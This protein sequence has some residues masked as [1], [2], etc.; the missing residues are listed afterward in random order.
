MPFV[1]WKFPFRCLVPTGYWFKTP[2]E[3]KSVLNTTIAADHADAVTVLRLTLEAPG[4]VAESEPQCKIQ[5]LEIFGLTAQAPSTAV[6]SLQ[7]STSAQFSLVLGLLWKLYRQH[8]EVEE[9]LAK[10]KH[11]ERLVEVLLSQL[12]SSSG[13]AEAQ[14]LVAIMARHNPSVSLRL[15]KETLADD[16]PVSQAKA[17]LVGHLCV[18]KDEGTVE[19]LA[20]VADYVCRTVQDTER[21]LTASPV[22][23]ALARALVSYTTQGGSLA[24]LQAKLADLVPQLAAMARASTPNSHVEESALML[25]TTILQL[26]GHATD[27]VDLLVPCCAPLDASGTESRPMLASLLEFSHPSVPSEANSA[28][29]LRLFAALLSTQPCMLEQEPFASVYGGFLHAIDEAGE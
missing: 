27:V 22:L 9:S 20:L 5:N 14:G 18:T 2:G 24:T 3:T 4:K 29:A 16:T 28:G 10:D 21:R 25:L 7:S 8:P 6:H 11:G 19:R 17:V 15:I 13:G 26:R 1:L 23:R 12:G